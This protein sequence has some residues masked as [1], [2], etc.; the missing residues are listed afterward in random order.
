MEDLKP[1][2]DV[3]QSVSSDVCIDVGFNSSPK[4]LE[5]KEQGDG[6]GSEAQNAKLIPAIEVATESD[7]SAG[8]AFLNTS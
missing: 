4:I 8:L 6:G 2:G 1:H 5:W 3:L 7:E